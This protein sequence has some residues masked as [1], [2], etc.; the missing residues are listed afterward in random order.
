MTGIIYC[1]ANSLK[2]TPMLPIHIRLRKFC[3]YAVV[4][5]LWLASAP[6]HATLNIEI[7]GGGATQIPIAIVPFAAEERL[8]QGITPVVSAD[9]QRSGLFRLVDP[10]GLRPH[11]PVE[12][13]YPDWTNRGAGALV[14][15]AP[16]PFREGRSPSVSD[17]WMW[18]SKRSW[19]F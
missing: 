16:Q 15:A 14:S 5:L 4:L 19:R 6:L 12:V 8:T 18:R 13:V 2:V 1:F 9:L 11:E 10:G 17:C 3:G 7:F